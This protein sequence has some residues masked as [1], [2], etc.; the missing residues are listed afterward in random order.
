MKSIKKL[1]LF[2]TAILLFSQTSFAKLPK[3]LYQVKVYR[4]R[5][6]EQLQQLDA[7]LKDAY[8]PALHRAGIKQVGVFKPLSNDTSAS[9]SIYVWIPFTSE[10]KFLELDKELKKDQVYLS[11]SKSFREAPSTNPP[12]DRIESM[13]LEAFEG[14]KHFVLPAKKQ[15][16]VFEWRSYESP[17]ENLHEKKMLMFEKEEIT[18]FKKLQ[19]NTV[20]Y[21]KVISGSRMP[22]FVYMPTF[23]SVDDRNAHWKT[24]GA[25]PDWKSMQE[26]PLYESKVSVSRNEN[27]LMY[28]ADYSDF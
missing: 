7:Y 28:A 5:T 12:F 25:D 3:D 9:K 2:V 6:S 22:N 24:F 13:L 17:T 1:F 4:F 15:G 10:K 23:Q 8:L 27:F 19:F 11:T 18:L 14:Q 20:F 16:T 21:A 26:N